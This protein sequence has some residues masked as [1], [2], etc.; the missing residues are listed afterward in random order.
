MRTHHATPHPLAT[1]TIAAAILALNPTAQAQQPTPTAQSPAAF[2]GRTFDNVPLSEAPANH[3][4]ALR[5]V[6]AT[7]WQE[8][9]LNARTPTSRILLESDVTISIGPFSFNANRAMVW[10]TPV[11]TTDPATNATVPAEQVAIFL[12]NASSTRSP[13]LN[14]HTDTR[15]TA[16]RLLVTA[17]ITRTGATLRA[18]DLIEGRPDFGAQLDFTQD[19]EQRLARHLQDLANANDPN[20]TALTPRAPTTTPNTGFN[21]AD[22]GFID[23]RTDIPTPPANPIR[24]AKRGTITFR[25]PDI[26]AVDDGQGATAII[27]DGGIGLEFLPADR[28]GSA[29]IDAQRAV[30]FLTQAPSLS[31]ADALDA[32]SIDGIYLEGDVNIVT[33][34]GD[35]AR[36]DADNNH[37]HLRGNRV[38]YAPLTE[39]ATVLDAV[40][41]TYDAKRGMPL[42]VRAEQIRQQSSTQWNA[43][44]AT[45]ANA[46]FAEPHFS[47]GATSITVTREPTRDGTPTNKLSAHGVTFR[48]N[49][50]PLFYLPHIEGEFQPTPLR[51]LNIDSEDGDPIV[52]AEWDLYAILGIDAG[53]TNSASLLTDLYT[54]RGAG[55]GTEVAW[56]T[57]RTTGNIFAYYIQDSGTDRLTTGARIERNDK[58][59]SLLLAETTWRPS[60]LWTIQAEASNI[61]DPAFI[62]SFFEQQA[63]TR[64]P[65]ATGIRA[66]RHTDGN[67]TG[68]LTIDA[69][70]FVDDFIPNEY[71][72]QSRG[73]QVE[74]LPEITWQHIGDNPFSEHINYFGETRIGVLDAEFAENELEDQGFTTQERVTD[75]FGPTLSPTDSLADQL[76]DQGFPDSAFTRFDTRHEFST[77]LNLGPVKVNPYTAGRFT[78]YD[79]DFESFD[80]DGDGIDD[81]QRL[82]ASVGLR[83]STAIHTIDNNA[84]SELL[85]IDRLRHIVEPSLHFWHADA[86]TDQSRIP[87]FDEGVESLAEDTHLKLGLRNTWQTKRGTPSNKRSVDW[88]TL[89]TDFIFSSQ[90]AENESPVNRFD[91]RRP[92]ESY[93]GSDFFQV[94][95]AIQATDAI[96]IIAATQYDADEEVVPFTTA[97]IL[98]DHGF[99]YSSTIEYRSV[100]EPDLDRFIATTRYELTRKYAAEARAAYDIDADDIQSLG[101]NIERRFPQWTF[102]WSLDFDDTRDLVNLSFSLRP[103]GFSGED[104]T[105]T[106]TEEFFKTAGSNPSPPVTRYS[107]SRLSTGPFAQ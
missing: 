41:W 97:G 70:G 106:F 107:T 26:T 22:E 80:P 64:R 17:V 103:V 93:L 75:A 99:G 44:N 15:Q 52:R 61:S 94:D 5:A 54:D 50:T 27:L 23:T 45:I 74:R 53:D 104:R 20:P 49:K 56:D 105:R 42:Y 51:Q 87:T 2:D 29:R 19:A 8:R 83:A 98:L 6:R 9:P 30:V 71:L 55:I 79:T 47:I 11:N 39:R 31:A 40:F 78:A 101:L 90:D 48:A 59:R 89:N 58:D 12:D 96:A 60:E 14:R 63:E 82:W 34:L 102:A 13:L 37:Y 18:D 33:L 16:D 10:I 67:A 43:A 24:A 88:L 65:Y 36:A 91:D 32:E 95:A 4:L 38:F 85:D 46:A 100:D 1:A 86:N 25:A 76:N 84:R 62:D 28:R 66:T 77:D 7:V 21:F 72:L 57:Q 92:E 35:P 69:R 81:S 3:A 73:Y 68:L